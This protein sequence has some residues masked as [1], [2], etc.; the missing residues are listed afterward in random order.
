MAQTGAEPGKNAQN[1]DEARR[2]AAE[3]HRQAPE[4]GMTEDAEER[5]PDTSVGAEVK[6]RVMHVH[7]GD[8]GR[9]GVNDEIYQGSKTR[10]LDRSA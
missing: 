6:P 8:V 7:K 9:P 2:D 5:A 4:H 3:N 1:A 10:E